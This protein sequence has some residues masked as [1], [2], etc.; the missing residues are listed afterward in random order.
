MM[1]FTDIFDDPELR[2]VFGLSRITVT[3]DDTGRTSRAAAESTLT[4]IILP[5]TDRELERLAEGDRSSEVVAV[6]SQTP[7]TSGTDELAPDEITWRERTYRVRQVQDWTTPAGYCLAL[8]V[9]IDLHGREVE[10]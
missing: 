5:A 8:A 4:G 10:A 6:Y 9:S 7:L 3:V 1:D 2:T